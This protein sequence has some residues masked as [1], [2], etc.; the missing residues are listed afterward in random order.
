MATAQGEGTFAERNLGRGEEGK[1][2]GARA[3]IAI[4]WTDV[5]NLSAFDHAVRW[6]GQLTGLRHLGD[7]LETRRNLET[8]CVTMSCR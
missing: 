3:L 2:L 4:E 7:I 8:T 5:G 1:G 6:P